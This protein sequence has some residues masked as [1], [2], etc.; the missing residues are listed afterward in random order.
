ML[1]LHR[2]PLSLSPKRS[3]SR[4][5]QSELAHRLLLDVAK[6][7]GLP[8]SP[9]LKTAQG[10]PYFRDLPLVDFSLSHTD[11][12]AVCA[13]WQSDTATPPRV[14]VD[15]EG[16]TDLDGNRIRALAERFFGT[17]ERR[18]VLDHNDLQT[19]FTEVFVRKEAYA[20]YKGDGLGMHLSRTDTL[21]P[22]FEDTNG[23]HFH[24]CREGKYFICLCVASTCNESPLD[25][26]QI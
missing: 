7:L 9:I 4:A 1:I 18:Y 22:V 6:K 8:P 24:A 5:A 17:H 11:G 23:V 2:A 20:K 14:G 21:A 19:A 25:F 16:L 15:V 12:I 3:E 13:L 10:R 26:T